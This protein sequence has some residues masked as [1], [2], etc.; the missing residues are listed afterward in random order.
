MERL[1]DCL[2]C[3]ALLAVKPH[4]W[5][6]WKLSDDFPHDIVG[7][8]PQRLFDLQHEV[9]EFPHAY[10]YGTEGLIPCEI[11]IQKIPSFI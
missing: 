6:D 11:N 4:L 3:K 1:V 10:L 7:E 9:G 5:L 2:W 8:I